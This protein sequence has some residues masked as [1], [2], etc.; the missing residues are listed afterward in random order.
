M[1]P[2]DWTTVCRK[3]L[4]RGRVTTSILALPVEVLDLVLLQLDWADAVRLSCAHPALREAAL[5][6][7]VLTWCRQP[8]IID[9]TPGRTYVC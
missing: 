9:G 2:S 6:L 8:I 5:S 4:D 1:R 7:Q 3:R